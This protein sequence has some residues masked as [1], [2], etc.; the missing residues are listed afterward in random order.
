MADQMAVMTAREVPMQSSSQV[1]PLRVSVS[2]GRMQCTMRQAMA[3]VTTTAQLLQFL[4]R[5]EAAD[6][7]GQMWVLN[8]AVRPATV[9]GMA[10]DAWAI[11]AVQFPSAA[12][13][14]VL[15]EVFNSISVGLQAAKAGEPARE[16]RLV[17][18][19]IPALCDQEA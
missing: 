9:V 12:S 16:D 18:K 11:V 14:T 4:P 1:R 6:R 3:Q 8:A 15:A 10:A 19:G 17:T 2:I 13:K 5:E 7:E